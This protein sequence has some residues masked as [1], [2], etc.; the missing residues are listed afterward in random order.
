MTAVAASSTAMTAVAA[1]STAMT[2][3]A[4]SSTAMTA[5]AASSTAMTAVAASST[6]MSAINANDVALNAL[7]ASPLI[8]KVS[9]SS[10]QVW[11]STQVL[12]NGAG[13]FVRLTTKAGVAGWGEGSAS[14]EWITYD[15]TNV[16]YAERNANPFNH[17]ATTA[18]APRHPARKFSSSLAIRPYQALEI[19]YI[20]L[21]S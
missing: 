4:A 21:S 5:V 18:A 13:L 3:V 10:A 11:S 2:A 8:S 20:P 9:Y 15:G 12:R 19:A 16:T 17:T 14:N 7:Y 6:A 1:S